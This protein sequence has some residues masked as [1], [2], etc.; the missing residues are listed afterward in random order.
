MN[1]KLIFS[2]FFPRTFCIVVVRRSINLFLL[3]LIYL[4]TLHTSDKLLDSDG[5]MACITCFQTAWS[6]NIHNGLFCR[7]FY[8]C[9]TV[10][11]CN[12]II[13]GVFSFS[14]IRWYFIITFC[15]KYYF[16]SHR[17]MIDDRKTKMLFWARNFAFMV[18]R[19]CILAIWAVVL[20]EKSN[21]FNARQRWIW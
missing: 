10:F 19:L 1:P 14:P 20:A 9:N 8:W 6:K 16:D 12:N 5:I 21:N 18:D 17:K 2:Y 13:L 15:F 3:T 11:F 7:T 4:E